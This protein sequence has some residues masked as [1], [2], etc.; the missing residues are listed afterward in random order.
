MWNTSTRSRMAAIEKKMKWYPS[1]LTDEEWGALEPWLP[2][3]SGHGRKRTTDLREVVN[4]LRY[5]ARSG[6]G[7]SP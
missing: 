6:C 5:M 3:T 4:A 2:Q 1:D 7:C